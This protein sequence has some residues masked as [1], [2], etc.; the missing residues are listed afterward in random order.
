[1]PQLASNRTLTKSKLNSQK[2]LKYSLLRKECHPKQLNTF[3]RL[4][5]KTSLLHVTG[6]IL[7]NVISKFTSDKGRQAWERGGE[8]VS[9]NWNFMVTSFW[10]TPCYLKYHLYR[11][12]KPFSDISVGKFTRFKNHSIFPTNQKQYLTA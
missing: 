8:G 6:K 12:A 5:R 7:K 1:M 2:K 4:K 3:V 9:K 11:L 10:M